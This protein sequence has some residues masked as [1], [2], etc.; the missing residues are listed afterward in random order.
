MRRVYLLA[1]LSLLG[2]CAGPQGP[3]TPVDSVCR[4][5]Q[6]YQINGTWYYPQQHYDYQEEGVASWYGPGF[7]GRKKAYGEIYDQNGISAAH[8]TLPLPTVVKVTNLR[9]GKALKLLVDDR[10]PYVGDRII[11]LSL[12]AAK[13]LG[14][15]NAG[16][17]QVRVEALPEESR[18]LSRH[19]G[20]FG[21][22]GIDP[23]GRT[24]NT[25]YTQEIAPQYEGEES[26]SPSFTEVSESKQ[27]SPNFIE[28]TP[29]DHMIE[30]A[31][32]QDIKPEA[33]SKSVSTKDEPLDQMLDLV[34]T[35]EAVQPKKIVKSP[36]A[37]PTKEQYF[38]TVGQHYL[39]E[40]NASQALS[41]LRPIAQ[42]EV[43]RFMA[44][45]KQ[46]LYTVKLGP[47]PSPSKATAAIQHLRNLGYSRATLSRS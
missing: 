31:A 17:A 19:L 34:Y 33:S 5:C 38:V 14:V 20:R 28:P 27:A 46:Y 2:G 3:V 37:R 44:G 32:R 45:Q 9:S 10:G 39:Q 26:R 16:I 25:I 13:E 41:E 36:Y 8:K 11:D 21:R 7:D 42:G 23:K 12:G 30:V 40:K 35:Q 47:F 6:P 18:A 15:A 29:L 43:N 22:T 4:S 1:T 24:W